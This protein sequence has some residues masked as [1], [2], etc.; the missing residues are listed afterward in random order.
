[1]RQKGTAAMENKTYYTPGTYWG[2]ITHQVLGKASTGNPQLLVSFLVL[3]R[4]N[5]ADPDGDLLSCGESYERTMYQTLTEK[6]IEFV[7]R[8]LERLGWAGSSWGD[9]DER[10]T[11]CVSI[12]GSEHA[13]YCSHKPNQDNTI[14]RENW[15]V[16]RESTAP[17]AEPLTDSEYRSL[18]AMF[19]KELKKRGHASAKKE[20]TAEKTPAPQRRATA[21]P[22]DAAA[23]VAAD[24]SDIPF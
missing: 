6:T 17:N 13:F 10:N 20:A 5:Q 3:G 15:S 24:E 9:F 16:A 14:L 8:D 2:R 7:T 21:P 1:M 22:V 23:D 11:G 4:V 12:V 19:G 18:D